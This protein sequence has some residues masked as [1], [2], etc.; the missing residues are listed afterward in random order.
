MGLQLRANGEHDVRHSI[1]SLCCFPL[2]FVDSTCACVCSCSCARVPKHSLHYH[3]HMTNIRNRANVDH[4]K[5]HDC[6]AA[7]ERTR[8]VHVQMKRRR[9]RASVR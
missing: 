8:M 5:R 9:V 2:N 7:Q 1:A 4:P 3:S 6:V